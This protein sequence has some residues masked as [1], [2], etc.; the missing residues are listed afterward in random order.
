MHLTDTGSNLAFKIYSTFTY[1]NTYSAVNTINAFLIPV[2]SEEC[3]NYY[4]CFMILLEISPLFVIKSVFKQNYEW[5]GELKPRMTKE[6]QTKKSKALWIVCKWVVN[7]ND[8]PND[9]LYQD[10]KRSNSTD[11]IYSVGSYKILY[12]L[13][14]RIHFF[15]CH[16]SVDEINQA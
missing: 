4:F 6:L 10:L 15:V 13:T 8:W 7:S 9:K 12:A 1:S 11:T 3:Q 16:C 5:P 2:K 14:S